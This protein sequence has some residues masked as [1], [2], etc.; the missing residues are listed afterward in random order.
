[1]PFIPVKADS[2]N[3]PFGKAP[4]DSTSFGFTP[5]DSMLS[6][7]NAQAANQTAAGP[8][9]LR[10]S[11][12][13]QRRARVAAM[14]L[15][16]QRR[17]RQML[18]ARQ[19]VYLVYPEQGGTGPGGAYD[20][21]NPVLVQG[22][23][24]QF[25][26]KVM[27][28]IQNF[29]ARLAPMTP[30]GKLT[31][32]PAQQFS[33]GLANLYPEIGSF[34]GGMLGGGK[35]AAG[36]I[37]AARLGDTPTLAQEL[38]TTMPGIVAG[39]TAGRAAG[40]A[41][42]LAQLRASGLP[43]INDPGQLVLHLAG[44]A[45]QGFG[46]GTVQGITG[47]LVTR[48]GQAMV[49]GAIGAADTMVPE[50]MRK[51]NLDISLANFGKGGRIEKMIDAATVESRAIATQLTNQGVRF[52]GQDIVGKLRARVAQAMSGELVDD[53]SRAAMQQEM[54][55]VIS[56][57][58][59]RIQP[60]MS[61]GLGTYV[62][63]R[64]LTPL[65]LQAIATEELNSVRRAV[66]ARAAGHTGEKLQ[67]LTPQEQAQYEIYSQA[68][69]LL[70]DLD[71]R[72]TAIGK[73]QH[74]LFTVQ[75][76]MRGVSRGKLAS[77]TV[78]P[79]ALLGGNAVIQAARGDVPAALYSGVSALGLNAIGQP[80]PWSRL[81][82]ALQNPMI[83]QVI[84]NAPRTASLLWDVAQQPYYGK[85]YGNIGNTQWI[86]GPIPSEQD[87]TSQWYQRYGSNPPQPR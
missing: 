70:D 65:D 30:E 37:A 74:E 76:A 18:R 38:S 22:A 27:N 61:G 75:N 3:D 56:N 66:A 19:G 5:A 57:L 6:D 73:K 47:P 84:A 7:I 45:A 53:A 17:A 78:M 51:Y 44:Q 40:A 63:P 31:L 10:M 71:P 39:S 23:A 46:E 2:T 77:A 25:D 80:Q 21:A 81:G 9:H 52:T 87:V 29:N 59:G 16:D 24:D 64:E 4:A 12:P 28:E 13:E 54:Q 15:E 35:K 20:L 83:A 72:L 1:M 41:L 33:Y 26:P 34:L 49:K 50:W 62:P 55:R 42:R 79:A 48:G 32:T 58:E 14:Q 36:A 67:A 8:A 86:P 68:R 43:T 85:P 69:S 82:I 60:S 11:T